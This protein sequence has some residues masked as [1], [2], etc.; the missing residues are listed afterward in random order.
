MRI[1]ELACD[2]RHL[3]Y[4]QMAGWSSQV[5]R[6][7]HNPKVAGSNPAPATKALIRLQ[8]RLQSHEGLLGMN[9]PVIPS[10]SLLLMRSFPP[11]AE[12]FLRPCLRF[13]LLVT[14]FGFLSV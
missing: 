7:A 5:A 4:N 12:S 8:A 10:R 11:S 14:H 9:K 3:C 1:S 13:A 6:W 2:P